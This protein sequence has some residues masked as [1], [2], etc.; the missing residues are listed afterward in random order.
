MPKKFY[1]LRLIILIIIMIFSAG[2]SKNATDDKIAYISANTNSEYS[3]VY[4]ELLLG[5]LF[6]FN[7]R[8]P[9]ADK[10]WV[11]IW[12]E[13]YRNGKSVEPLHI[14]ELTYGLNPEKKVEGHMGFGMLYNNDETQVFLY[15]KGIKTSNQNITNLLSKHACSAWN[16][17][18]GDKPVGIDS[19][20]EVILATYIQN[21]GSIKAGY[22]YTDINSIK[23]MI[24]ENKTVLLLK[25]KIEKK[26]KL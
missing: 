13:A 6:D 14:I 10:S 4:K 21:E 9:D 11:T 3:K 16:Y 26:E 12:V 25:I 8:L 15:S 23:Q 22:D 17:A 5:T 2:C 18:I 7:L 24:S 20:K 1:S 19:G